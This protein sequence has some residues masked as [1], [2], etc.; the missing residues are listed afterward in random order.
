MQAVHFPGQRIEFGKL[1]QFALA[2]VALAD[3]AQNAMRPH[4]LAIGTREPAPG[5]FQ[6]DFLVTVP[7]G[8]LQ[9][10]GNALAGIAL[11]RRIDGVVTALA[12]FS[13]DLLRKTAA[14]GDFTDGDAEQ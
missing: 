9:L 14:A 4:R 6:P 3:R 10:V 1:Q 13:L 2:R 7:E 11:R 5:V 12:F 8:I